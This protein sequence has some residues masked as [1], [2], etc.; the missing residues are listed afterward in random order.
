MMLTSPSL[1]WLNQEQ[2]DFPICIALV[3]SKA[4]EP[5]STEW[6]LPWALQEFSYLFGLWDEWI[7]FNVAT[8]ERSNDY[9]VLNKCSPCVSN[10]RGRW[11]YFGEAPTPMTAS[12]YWV[13][14][15]YGIL[16][17]SS[18]HR[19]RGS[20]PARLQVMVN[21]TQLS[22]M[23]QLVLLDDETQRESLWDKLW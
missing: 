22:L 6:W 14:T 4:T 8:M 16:I 18:Y 11:H 1:S 19:M 12:I 7:G 21:L 15:I 13:P 5:Q 23:S 17:Y 20:C 3:R 2:N 9:H 10:R